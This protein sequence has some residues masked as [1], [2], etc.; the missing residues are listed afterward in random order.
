[1]K[2]LILFLLVSFNLTVFAQQSKVSIESFGNFQF[3]MTMKQAQDAI[4]KHKTADTKV[5][6][7]KTIIEAENI[8]LYDMVFN[9]CTLSFDKTLTMATFEKQFFNPEIAKKQFDN[10]LKIMESKYGETS[11]SNWTT[12]WSGDKSRVILL[13]MEP[14]GNKTILQ[15]SFIGL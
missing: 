9:K 11:V 13:K 8:E 6:K 14:K 2:K 7:W 1:M 3:G 12:A 10:L 4:K 15:L 5:K